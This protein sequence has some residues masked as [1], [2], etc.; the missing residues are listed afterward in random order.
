MS[1]FGQSEN[2]AGRAFAAREMA[3]LE[4]GLEKNLLLLGI[5]AALALAVKIPGPGA[6]LSRLEITGWLVALIFLGEG[7]KLDLSRLA[8]P[9]RY[10]KPAL[11][12]LVMAFLV[13]P[14]GAFLMAKLFSLQ[15]DYLVGLV[16]I[17][18]LPCSLASATVI[19]ANADGDSTAALF[20]LLALNLV[21]L[22]ATPELLRLWLGGAAHVDDADIM[23]KLVLY[24]FIPVAAGQLLKWA[25]PALAARLRP[26]FRY[27]PALCIAV[28]IYAS[29]AK[30]SARIEA[31]SLGGVLHL[32]APCLLLHA[33][34]LALSFGSGRYLLHLE[35][36]VNRAVAVICSEKPLSLAVALWSL[37][38][39]K[40]HPLAVFPPVMI[41]IVQVLLDS[42]WAAHVQ[43]R[44]GAQDTT[45]ACR[46]G[47][48]QGKPHA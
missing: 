17:C 31:L 16:L 28:I 8:S 12:G 7:V 29:C 26:A 19:S 32:L 24:L 9:S 10:V 4:H 18:S 21:G 15:S 22:V 11:L 46:P 14:A 23:L 20:L 47:E 43:G 5:L 44:R 27:V 35:E 40:D 41:Y 25:A 3:K 39:A 45:S 33:A 6:A 38:F 48:Q 34:V 36:R 1:E 37:S 30:E 42:A 2:N 13:F